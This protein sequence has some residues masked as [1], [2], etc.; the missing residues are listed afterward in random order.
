MNNTKQP[1][2]LVTGATGKTGRRVVQ[3]LQALGHAVRLGSR[4]AEPAFDWHRPETW[5]PVLRGVSAVYL[6]YQPDLAVPG[7]LETVTG[8][9]KAAAGAGVDRVV[10][11]SGRGEDAAQACEAAVRAVGL[12]TTVVRASWFA[13]NFSEGHFAEQIQ[14]GQVAF[15]GGGVPE[16]FIDVDDIADVVTAALTE[17]GHAGELYEVTGPRLLT[18]GEAVAEIGAAAGRAIEYH[19]IP[20]DVFHAGMLEAGMPEDLAGFLT[21][22]A[23]TVLDGRNAQVCDGVERALG[24]PA[25]DFADYARHAAGAGIWRAA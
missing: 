1:L 17:D 19:D 23:T 25:R 21:W 11:L 8:F 9:T 10:L 16:P 3:R 7:A 15:P 4:S 20:G 12:P 18:F 24:R 5:A 22:L 6:C 2:T 13:Q 14:A